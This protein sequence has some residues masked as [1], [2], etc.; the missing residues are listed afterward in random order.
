LL[1][2]R[3]LSVRPFRGAK[4]VRVVDHLASPL[5][6]SSSL[7][8]QKRFR[9]ISGGSSACT[10][11]YD[12]EYRPIARHP[13]QDVHAALGEGHAGSRHKILDRA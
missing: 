2:R 8:W 6:I 1:H 11:I 7:G 13:L 4:N 5:P 10:G 9:A 3:W 12:T